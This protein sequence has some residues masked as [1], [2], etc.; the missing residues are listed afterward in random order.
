MA[1]FKNGLNSILALRSKNLEQGKG[2]L[3]LSVLTS[4]E[5]KKPPP[6]SPPPFS[7]QNR[8]HDPQTG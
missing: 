4:K 3:L 7:Q 8:P 5:G 2:N 1:K 6:L